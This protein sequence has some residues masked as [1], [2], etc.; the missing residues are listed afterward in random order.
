[1][2]QDGSLH[3]ILTDYLQLITMKTEKCTLT[4]VLNLCLLCNEDRN[5][6]WMRNRSS[7]TAERIVTALIFRKMKLSQPQFERLKKLVFQWFS[8]S[9]QRAGVE[10]KSRASVTC[11]DVLLS[12]V[13]RQ[14]FLPH[15][16]W[17]QAV[18]HLRIKLPV[19]KLW[20]T[21][22]TTNPLPSALFHKE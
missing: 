15:I 3:T 11:C 6:Y 22:T 10:F 8:L 17:G 19:A 9:F 7:R 5:I 2:M 12:Y 20:C 21:E 13:S 18:T 16:I 1:M 14:L 4:K